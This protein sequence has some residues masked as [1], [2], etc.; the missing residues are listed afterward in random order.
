MATGVFV[1]LP[2]ETYHLRVHQLADYAGEGWAVWSG[3][4]GDEVRYVEAPQDIAEWDLIGL[5]ADAYLDEEG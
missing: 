5:L 2:N 1:N 4:I 3:T